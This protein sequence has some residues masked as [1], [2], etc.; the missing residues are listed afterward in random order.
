MILSASYLTPNKFKNLK[1]MKSSCLSICTSFYYFLNFF[2]VF[3]LLLVFIIIQLLYYFI[4]P[5]RLF[6]S[7]LAFLALDED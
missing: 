6:F 5:N 7:H 1:H 2:I 4:Y 3:L